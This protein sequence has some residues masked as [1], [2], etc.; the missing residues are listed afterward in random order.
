[1][2]DIGLPAN[3]TFTAADAGAHVFQVVL[4]LAWEQTI[5]VTDVDTPAI[6]GTAFGLLV[7]PAAAYQI[8]IWYPTTEQAGVPFTLIAN[9]EDMYGNVVHDYTGTLHFASTDPAATLPDD[10]TLTASDNGSYWFDV[11]FGTPG[12]QTLTVTD[13]AGILVG[14]NMQITVS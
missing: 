10:Y 7:S 8:S 4:Y 12:T 5:T 11:T 13:L 9:M 3:Y 14:M 6:A 1:S 2:W